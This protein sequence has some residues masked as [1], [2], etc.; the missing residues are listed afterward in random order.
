M[1]YHSFFYV[2]KGEHTET[3]K[4]GLCEKERGSK[5]LSI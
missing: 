2:L 3:L 5:V 4:N 1:L